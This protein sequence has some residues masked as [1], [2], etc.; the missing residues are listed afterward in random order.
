MKAFAQ[1]SFLPSGSN[2]TCDIE[3]NKKLG[4]LYSFSHFSSPDSLGVIHVRTYLNMRTLSLIMEMFGVY[5]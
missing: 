1:N 2:L 3:T 5:H 4:Y